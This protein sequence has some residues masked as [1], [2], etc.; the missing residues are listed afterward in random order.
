MSKKETNKDN[1]SPDSATTLMTNISHT[2]LEH[3]VA[4]EILE[5]LNRAPLLE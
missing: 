1:R 3:S 4:T 5:E 2:D